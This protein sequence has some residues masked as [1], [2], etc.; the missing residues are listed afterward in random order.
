MPA[1]TVKPSCATRS[2]TSSA[3]TTSSIELTLAHP[4]EGPVMVSDSDEELVNRPLDPGDDMY[5]GKPSSRVVTDRNVATSLPRSRRR[6]RSST[7]HSDPED[8]IQP[9]VEKRSRFAVDP[10]DSN[11]DPVTPKTLVKSFIDAEA[12]G[13][14][15]SELSE[16][17]D[18][19]MNEDDA[20]FIDDGPLH[21]D[22]EALYSNR[23]PISVP[24][25]PPSNDTVGRANMA[26]DSSTPSTA[27]VRVPPV[28]STPNAVLSSPFPGSLNDNSANDFIQTALQNKDFIMS[29]L[30]L[31]TANSSH[32]S[33]Y[34]PGLQGNTW[35][36][37]VQH[38][39][40]Q[41]P[42]PLPS[43][44]PLS[45]A[46]VSQVSSSTTASPLVEPVTP[47]KPR[48][49]P[50]QKGKGKEKTVTR[51]KKTQPTLSGSRLT[52]PALPSEATP[53]AA[54]VTVSTSTNPSTHTIVPP[55][56]NPPL[57][58]P[59]PA[60]PSPNSNPSQALVTPAPD[61][62]VQ[63]TASAV[64]PTPLMSM[65]DLA[66]LIP[67][68][69]NVGGE[70]NSAPGNKTS[71]RL[72]P[73]LPPICEVN[74]PQL[75]DP[76]LAQTYAGLVNLKKGRFSSWSSNIGRGQVV[77]STWVTKTP[78]MNPNTA[79]SILTLTQ[80]GRF[81][82]P[83]RLSPL[84][85]QLREVRVNNNLR[86]NVYRGDVPAI[87]LSCGY[88]WDSFL[89]APKPIGLSQKMVSV[90][91]HKQEW[92]RLVAFCC[93]IF[94]VDVIA[95]QVAQSALQFSTR[96]D[97]DPNVVQGQASTATPSPSQNSDDHMFTHSP[98]SATLTAAPSARSS[99]SMALSANANIPIYDAR[100][101]NFNFQ[102]DINEL[103]RLPLWDGEIPRGSFVVVGYTLAAYFPNQKWNLATNVR[104]VVVVGVPE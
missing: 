57:S 91:L 59:V 12:I 85:V 16:F 19:E 81:I 74:D 22:P 8:G 31:A 82:N 11:T 101:T 13:D 46:G 77:F 72:C 18:S 26:V 78:N 27:E 39:M 5:R 1:S 80:N 103:H 96:S 58:L 49:K 100:D 56:N 37:A 99:E 90:V 48:R 36:S 23:D 70:P 87:A 15:D 89:T 55:P 41:P 24:A 83:S 40:A 66:P 4:Q 71:L 76:L 45:P 30:Q 68:G 95:A 75:H 52:I 51:P 79:F 64:S 35:S 84:E 29:L 28:V 61:S 93:M 6:T 33:P 69:F 92:E 97:W 73:P 47:S 3:A 94:N 104:W 86:Y 60:A 62:I 21:S 17:D 10:P 25:C 2:K 14:N 88:L 65:K 63:Q 20:A 102:N 32:P 44:H 9:P 67:A 42:S 7:A 98:S 43:K 54:P 38:F 53:I 50:A 34:I